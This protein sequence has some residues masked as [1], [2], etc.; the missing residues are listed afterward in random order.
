ML[1]K[2]S[3]LSLS[4]PL[5]FLV[6]R[7]AIAQ[8]DIQSLIANYPTAAA[9]ETIRIPP[10][11]I[12]VQQI[13]SDEDINDSFSN[14]DELRWLESTARKNRMILPGESHRSQT[15][16][17]LRNRILFVLNTFDPFPLIVL[18]KQFSHSE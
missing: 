2:K 5:W 6:C 15:I 1:G 16:H 12:T 8:P 17:H 10:Q 7:S 13:V 18:E 4:L 9:L 3:N 11:K 14:I